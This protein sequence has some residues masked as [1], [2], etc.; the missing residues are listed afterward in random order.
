MAFEKLDGPCPCCGKP[1]EPTDLWFHPQSGLLII[2]GKRISLTGSET[3][4]FRQLVQAH[5]KTITV[6][7]IIKE[8]NRGR[9]DGGTTENNAHALLAHLK[10]KLAVL[11]LG[12]TRRHYVLVKLG[13]KDDPNRVRDP[14]PR[15][16]RKTNNGTGDKSSL[17][18]AG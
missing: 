11:G 7:E 16:P 1:L 10:S 5:P 12:I 2:G 18:G 6:N 17:H 9:T 14:R 4:I 3:V 13:D 8:M 15:G